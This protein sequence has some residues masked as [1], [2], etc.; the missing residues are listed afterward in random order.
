MHC[1]LCLTTMNLQL[2][3]KFHQFL[4]STKLVG[5]I[6]CHSQL[7]YKL[8]YNTLYTIVLLINVQSVII[9]SDLHSSYVTQYVSLRLA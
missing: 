5:Y 9:K 4:S 3:I 7:F 6:Q 8:N 2:L 1:K